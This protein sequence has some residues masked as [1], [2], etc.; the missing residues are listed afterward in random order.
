MADF[1][2]RFMS[3]V[4]QIAIKYKHK[5]HSPDV[6]Y[7]INEFCQ[8]LENMPHDN[9]NSFSED[10]TY[11]SCGT[12]NSSISVNTSSSKSISFEDLSVLSTE[13]LY[14]HDNNY[15]GI[16]IKIKIIRSQISLLYNIIYG[17]NVNIK[18]S[19]QEDNINKNSIQQTNYFN[20]GPIKNKGIKLWD[21]VRDGE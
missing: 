10:S 18:R 5:S 9:T 20:E 17:K 8:M 1:F 14:Y 19:N 4:E 15:E 13:S 3:D 11:S 7:D 16:G 12:I 6:D 2:E 21:L